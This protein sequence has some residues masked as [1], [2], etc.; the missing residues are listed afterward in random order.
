MNSERSVEPQSDRNGGGNIAV[1]VSDE[2][3][4]YRGGRCGV[5][6]FHG[7]A[8][9]EAAS[10][11]EAVGGDEVLQHLQFTCVRRVARVSSDDLFKEIE[12][13]PRRGG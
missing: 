7:I 11:I 8:H 12:V 6:I 13:C 4:A 2:G 5:G 9:H 3:E 10:G 1:S